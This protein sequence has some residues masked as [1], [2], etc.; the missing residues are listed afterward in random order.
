LLAL[1]L[2]SV[3]CTVFVGGPDFPE[4]R[5]PV[6]V[7]AA[8]SIK[9]QI[10]LAMES[11]LATGTFTLQVNESQLTSYFAAKL[12][13]QTNPIMSEPQIYLQDGQMQVF[14]KVQRGIFAANVSIVVSVGV[15][16]NG[17]PAVEVVSTDFGPLPAP[18]GLNSAIGAIV[19]EAYT[20]SLGPI[21]TGLRLESISITDG[22]MTLSGRLR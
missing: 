19:A 18:E 9:D 7:E 16:E 8:E 1:W 12:D 15:D 20:G 10:R 14:G 13:E 3:A 5:I 6:S 4:E 11:G 22:V 2:A 21:A 17:L